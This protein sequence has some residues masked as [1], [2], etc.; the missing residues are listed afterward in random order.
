M[1]NSAFD[2]ASAINSTDNRNRSMNNRTN[3]I[4]DGNNRNNRNNRNDG[5]NNGAMIIAD[6]GANHGLNDGTNNT[7]PCVSFF[8][9]R[10]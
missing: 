7:V 6:G 1:L 8:S 10:V 4:N 2:M 3:N 5:T 9:S